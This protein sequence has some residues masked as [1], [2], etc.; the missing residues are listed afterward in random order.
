MHLHA[1]ALTYMQVAQRVDRVW[2]H[3]DFNDYFA[4]CPDAADAAFARLCAVYPNALTIIV[5]VDVMPQVS[6]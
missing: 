5:A 1:C 6:G 4:P 3:G 2:S